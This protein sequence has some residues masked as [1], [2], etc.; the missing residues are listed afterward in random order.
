PLRYRRI[1]YRFDWL[2]RQQTPP[3]HRKVLA[4][5]VRTRLWH[6]A[7]M[8][9]GFHSKMFLDFSWFRILN[10]T[11]WMR[12]RREGYKVCGFFVLETLPDSPGRLSGPDTAVYPPAPFTHSF[13]HSLSDAL[14][15]S[16]ID[17]LTHSFTH[18]LIVSCPQPCTPGLFAC[19]KEQT[20]EFARFRPLRIVVSAHFDVLVSPLLRTLCEVG[21][22]VI[23]SRFSRID[24]E[25]VYTGEGF[26]LRIFQ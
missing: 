9:I 12:S 8:T 3:R 2:Q 20:R 4:H 22:V 15:H 24:G 5:P 13:T 6:T 10:C 18:S 14:T 23:S 16:L 26:C 17:S 11:Y 21:E 7:Y 19:I 25:D 1:R